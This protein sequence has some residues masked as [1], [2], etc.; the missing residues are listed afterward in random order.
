[1]LLVIFYA[2]ESIWLLV[3]TIRPSN[4]ILCNIGVIL[5]LGQYSL[6]N[7][8]CSISF[9]DFINKRWDKSKEKVPILW[10][11]L[12]VCGHNLMFTLVHTMQGRRQCLGVLDLKGQRSLNTWVWS[13]LDCVNHWAISKF[14]IIPWLRSSTPTRQSESLIFS[15]SSTTAGL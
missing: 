2:M 4:A 10:K 1:M 3:N 11:Q 6:T 14:I 15:P 8:A 5:T 7:W 9:A 12:F 13:N